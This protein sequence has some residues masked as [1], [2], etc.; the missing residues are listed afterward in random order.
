MKCL[1]RGRK[2]EERHF[3]YIEGRD[4]L[5]ATSTKLLNIKY[6]LH[7]FSGDDEETLT[8][9]YINVVRLFCRSVY[10]LHC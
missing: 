4:N 2:K 3:L 10:K 6:E 1:L 9:E 5:I 8:I 7:G